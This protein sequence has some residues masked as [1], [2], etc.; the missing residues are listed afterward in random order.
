MKNVWSFGCSFSSGYLDV[1]REDTYCS[2]LAKDLGFK[3]NNFAEPGF[4]NERIFNTLTSNLDKI[5]TGDV[6]IYQFTFF[7]RIGLFKDKNNIHTYVSSAGLPDFGIEHKMKE[8]SYSGLSYDE[9]SSLLDFTITWQD[10]RFLFTYTN[11]INTL[12]F[13]KKTK[14]TKNFIIF[15][16]KEENINLD[17]VLLFPFKNNLENTSWIDY[18]SKKKLTIDC[19][20]PKKYKNDGHP[21]FKAHIDLKNKILK[22]LK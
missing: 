9:V 12:N 19:E 5:K 7:N 22:E 15:L 13:L 21:G 20:F 18:I 1:K 17:N 11:P 3:S 6:V 10:R 2:L 16:Q 4:C 14:K 8:E